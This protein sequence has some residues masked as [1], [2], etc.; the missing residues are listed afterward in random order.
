MSTL[1]ADSR[2]SKRA[3]VFLQRNSAF[4]VF[5]NS[6]STTPLCY[7]TQNFTR[8]LCSQIS[9]YSSPAYTYPNTYCAFV[10]DKRNDSQTYFHVSMTW[11]TV[12]DAL[13][14]AKGGFRGGRTV[15]FYGHCRGF[16]RHSCCWF[17]IWRELLPI[18][19]G[20]AWGLPTHNKVVNRGRYIYMYLVISNVFWII[21]TQCTPTNLPYNLRATLFTVCKK[22]SLF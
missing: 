4:G 2:T 13:A 12:R 20:L 3:N 16:W 10:M 1:F 22:K 19:S 18:R 8:V 15:S 17:M 5:Q 7:L 9:K 6:H 14:R 21:Q 11:V